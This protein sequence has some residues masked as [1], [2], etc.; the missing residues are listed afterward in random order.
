MVRHVEPFR[1]FTWSKGRLSE[2]SWLGSWSILPST[3][4][5]KKINFFATPSFYRFFFLFLT[6]DFVFFVT[7]TVLLAPHDTRHPPPI[8]LYTHLA[9]ILPY[10]SPTPVPLAPTSNPSKTLF[11]Y[12]CIVFLFFPSG[13]PLTC[14]APTEDLLPPF[15]EGQVPPRPPDPPTMHFLSESSLFRCQAKSPGLHFVQVFFGRAGTSALK[16]P[17]PPSLALLCCFISSPNPLQPSCTTY[18][19]LLFVFLA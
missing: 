2:P 13:T 5:K 12:A 17:C 3:N 4:V 18:V 10:T 9:P 19:A 11:F 7:F 8:L 6:I 15:D 14:L 16:G 1:R